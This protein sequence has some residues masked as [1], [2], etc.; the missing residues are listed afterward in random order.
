MALDSIDYR[1]QGF[2]ESLIELY[3]VVPSKERLGLHKTLAGLQVSRLNANLNVVV[4]TTEFEYAVIFFPFSRLPLCHSENAEL[5]AEE[6][7]LSCCM[8]NWL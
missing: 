8:G 2:A 4:K 3:C 1:V 7:M 6:G 5:P